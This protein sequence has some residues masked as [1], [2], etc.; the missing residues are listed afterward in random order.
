MN[1]IYYNKS[2][3][4]YILLQLEKRFDNANIQHPDK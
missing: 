2:K 1:I 3:Y 4:F